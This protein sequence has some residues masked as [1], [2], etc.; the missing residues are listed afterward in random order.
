MGWAYISPWWPWW[1]WWPWCFSGP[2]KSSAGRSM[3]IIPDLYIYVC[4]IHYESMMICY[5]VLSYAISWYG[6]LKCHVFHIDLIYSIFSKPALSQW[7]NLNLLP[8]PK[9]NCH[10]KPFLG[11]KSPYFLPLKP[12]CWKKP[13]VSADFFRP[14]SAT[15]C[16]TVPA[17]LL[18]PLSFR[19][20]R[21][22][23][24]AFLFRQLTDPRTL[25]ITGGLTCLNHHKKCIK[26]YIFDDGTIPNI[27]FPIG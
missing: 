10:S 18:G 8:F 9:K 19:S 2:Y 21:I 6:M 27:E 26:I 17:T 12:I 11:W 25:K 7:W 14:S 13:R 3:S 24:P 15:R 20:M 22:G 16:R 4:V 1:P 23:P 5:M